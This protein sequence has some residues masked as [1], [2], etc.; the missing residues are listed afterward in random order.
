MTNRR[1]FL[2]TTVTAALGT[3]LASSATSGGDAFID[4]HVHV[5]TPDTEKYPL[6][7]GFLK[8]NMAP[9]S[10]TPEQLFAHCKPEGV[11]RIVLIQMSYYQTDNRYMLDMMAAHPGTFSGVAIIDEK[12][13]DVRGRMKALAKQGVRG[14]RLSPKGKDVEG[15]LASPGIEEMWKVGGEEGL[16][17][18]LL[19]NPE[20]LGP[21]AG[22]CARNP[23][24]PVVIDHFARVGM[25][26][27]LSRADLDRLLHLS[28]YPKVT[29]KT[30][31]FYALGRKTPPYLD[32]GPMIKECRDSFGAERLMWA[33]DCPFQVDPGHNYH[34]SIALIRD[35]LD[36]LT[37]SD[38]AWMLR[39]TAEKVFFS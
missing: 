5:W 19:V 16:N 28:K 31:A 7:E 24:T 29:L 17:M 3:Q 36:F 12:A 20:A 30:S 14:F 11:T 27:P 4:A 1:Q 38:K 2:A 35:R 22:M 37:S 10:F 15:W 34:D 13:P 6:A 39:K 21:V 33:S 9:P 8:K 23:Q 25:A 32:L 18:C 26:G